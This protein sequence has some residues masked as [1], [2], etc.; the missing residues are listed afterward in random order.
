MA[1]NYTAALEAVLGTLQSTCRNESSDK[2]YKCRRE[3]RERV[4]MEE[5]AKCADPHHQ[6]W[7]NAEFANIK[8]C[9]QNCKTHGK[10]RVKECNTRC[11]NSLVQGIWKR[12]N[13]P[14][15]ESIA[16]KYA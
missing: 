10:N 5:V 2:R 16:S 12:V 7:K 11:L 14:E 8:S 4:I 9:Y 15:F 6:A 13:V 3:M 1:E